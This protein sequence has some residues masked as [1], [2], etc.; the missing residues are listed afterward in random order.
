MKNKIIILILAFLYGIGMEAQLPCYG[1]NINSACCNG[2]INTDKRGGFAVN[3]DPAGILNEL[4]WTKKNW[5]IIHNPHSTGITYDNITNPFYRQG[6]SYD[7]LR[8][9]GFPLS[10][11]TM[12]SF[13]DSLDFQARD[14]WQLLHAH[15]NYQPDF[16]NKVDIDNERE[17]PYLIL[18]NNVNYG[19]I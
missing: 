6:S 8:N 11:F 19:L 18:Y 14:G 3:Q 7:E 12:P 10:V 9:K 13:I 4:D 1:P 5:D 17:G 2:I 15:F 16:V